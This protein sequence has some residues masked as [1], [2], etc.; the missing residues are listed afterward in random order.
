MCVCFNGITGCLCG[1]R[2]CFVCL[3]GEMCVLG[4]RDRFA[5]VSVCIEMGVCV[6]GATGDVWREKWRSMLNGQEWGETGG[7]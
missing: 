6:E 4:E 3:Y 1:W 2:D 7:L 5:C